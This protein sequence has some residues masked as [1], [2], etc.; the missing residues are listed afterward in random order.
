MKAAY[1]RRG[2]LRNGPRK[3]IVQPVALPG[4]AARGA[5]RRL[6][7]KEFT[8]RASKHYAET[9]TYDIDLFYDTSRLVSFPKVGDSGDERIELCDRE[10]KY[11][12]ARITIPLAFP[13][14]LLNM[15][16]RVSKMHVYTTAHG[17]LRRAFGCL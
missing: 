13:D 16:L 11:Y 9:G 7:H 10:V 17:R 1:V 4:L 5:A 3:V 6:S 12:T 8:E 2:R 15:I 14:D